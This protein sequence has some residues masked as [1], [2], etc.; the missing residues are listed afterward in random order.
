LW[1]PVEILLYDWWPITEER[2]KIKRLIEGGITV[3]AN[4]GKQKDQ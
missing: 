1:R 4:H 2:K 3:N